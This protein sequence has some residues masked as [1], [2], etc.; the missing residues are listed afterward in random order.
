MKLR[1]IFG[2][3]FDQFGNKEQLDP[4]PREAS[5]QEANRIGKQNFCRFKTVDQTKKHFLSLD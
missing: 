2:K 1:T 5:D 3:A 4:V